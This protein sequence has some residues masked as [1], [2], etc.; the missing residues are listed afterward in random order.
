MLDAYLPPDSDQRDKRPAV[1]FIHGGGFRK[2]SKSSG[3]KI[4][5][6][7][8]MRGYAVFSI[9]YRLTRDH[10]KKPVLEA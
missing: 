3:S 6:E 8:A 7:L 1:V 4:A 9:N 2:G 10:S 5:K